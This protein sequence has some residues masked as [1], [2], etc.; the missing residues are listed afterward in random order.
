MTLKIEL[1]LIFCEARRVDDAEFFP[2]VNIYQGKEGYYWIFA[3]LDND[4]AEPTDYG[5]PFPTVEKALA[6]ADNYCNDGAPSNKE[7]VNAQG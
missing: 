2:L 7:T 5:G 3:D 1:G 4:A 6:D